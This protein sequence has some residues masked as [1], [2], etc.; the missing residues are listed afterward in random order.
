MVYDKYTERSV[1]KNVS[2]PDSDEDSEDHE[3]A[4]YGPEAG[5]AWFAVIDG[6]VYGPYAGIGERTLCM[7]PEGTTAFAAL[8]EGYHLVVNGEEIG[9]YDWV[10]VDWI[11]DWDADRGGGFLRDGS[12][13]ALARRG[14]ER[15]L[16][17]LTPSL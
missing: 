17:T 13:I 6:N 12:L 4:V 9:S 1:D 3:W 8:R 16:L 14:G 2:F 11:S 15:L 10:D 7:G 5:G